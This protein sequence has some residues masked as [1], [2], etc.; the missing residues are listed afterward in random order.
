MHCSI[1]FTAYNKPHIIEKTLP[2]LCQTTS[3]LS[4]IYV[5]DNGSEK[6]TVDLLKQIKSKY[7]RLNLVLNNENLGTAAALNQVISYI[8]EDHYFM[9]I[10]SDVLI[11]TDGWDAWMMRCLIHE[12]SVGLL[13]IR[14]F[15][16]RN[17]RE[18]KKTWDGNEIGL[19][20]FNVMTGDAIMMSPST[21][22]QM[23]YFYEFGKYGLE[24][25]EL[26]Y[27]VIICRMHLAYVMHFSSAGIDEVPS[28]DYKVFK[29]SQA[30]ENIKKYW[31]RINYIKNTRNVYVPNIHERKLGKFWEP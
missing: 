25:S 11:E 26:F 27:R 6:E 24:D 21:R 20:D 9:K 1:A 31:P 3:S 14:N 18:K 29:D 13:G 4:N 15:A 17:P 30:A 19:V 23:G 22:Q 10:D 5:I 28:G 7:R 2:V 8:P 12:P 16:D